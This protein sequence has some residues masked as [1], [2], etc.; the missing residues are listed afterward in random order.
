[1]PLPTGDLGSRGNQDVINRHSQDFQE[2]EQAAVERLS[3]LDSLRKRRTAYLPAAG[4]CVMAPQ[5][6]VAGVHHMFG[7]LRK[8][9]WQA[10]DCCC[11]A[12]ETCLGRLLMPRIL[13][14]RTDNNQLHI[15]M[16]LP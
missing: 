1:M 12:L 6:N 3:G 14:S 10:G 5:Q 7:R 15:A 2:L 11:C 9:A 8:A 16:H 13:I 4:G